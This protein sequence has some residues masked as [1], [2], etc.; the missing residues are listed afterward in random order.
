MKKKRADKPVVKQVSPLKRVENKINEDIIVPLEMLLDDIINIK[1]DTPPAK[2]PNMDIGR[3]LRSNN[4]A[5][6]G[7]KYVVEWINLHLNEFNEAY[8][9]T[10]EYVVEG[11]SWL[12]RPQLNRIIKNFEKNVG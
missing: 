3:L 2:I 8:N 6:N 7:I 10:D 5:G 4:A 12:R 1:V 11:Y 9:K